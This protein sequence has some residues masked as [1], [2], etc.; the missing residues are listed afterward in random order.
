M[1]AISGIRVQ[2]DRTRPAGEQVVAVHLADGA[3]LDDSKLYSVTT[4]DFVLAGGD[5]FSEFAKGT[6]IVDTGIFLRDVLVDYIKSRRNLS[7]RV[8]GRIVVN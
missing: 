8:D 3:A 7:P 2:F 4:N 6:D 1:M 5:G